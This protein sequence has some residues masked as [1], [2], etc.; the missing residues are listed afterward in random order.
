MSMDRK[1]SIVLAVAFIAY[2]LYLGP[3][4]LTLVAVCYMVLPMAA[5]WFGN[6]LGSQSGHWLGRCYI[7]RSS[8]GIMVKILGWILLCLAPLAVHTVKM[9]LELGI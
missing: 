2:A 5:I 8:P 7:D 9:R 3:P 4:A 6:E 1:I